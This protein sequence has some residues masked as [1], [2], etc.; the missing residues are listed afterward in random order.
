MSSAR[1]ASLEVRHG[2]LEAKIAQETK[3][4]LPDE[5][6]IADLKRQKLQIKD[7]LSML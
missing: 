4:P 7:Q 1:I 5:V 2:Q 3:R 6:L